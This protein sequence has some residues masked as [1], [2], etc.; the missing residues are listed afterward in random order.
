MKRFLFFI[1]FLSVFFFSFLPTKD[2][3]FGWHY[4]CGKEFFKNPKICI[5]NNFSYYLSD[6]KSANPH[7]VYDLILS[8]IFD[9]FG[10]NGLSFFY[11]IIISLC[12]FIF[13]KIIQPWWFSILAFNFT[14]F[15]SYNVLGL[16]LRSQIFSYLFFLISLYLIKK[17]KNNR[18]ILLLFPFLIFLWVN[19]HIGFFIGLILLGF[20]IFENLLL[21]QLKFKFLKYFKNGDDKTLSFLLFIFFISIIFSLIN[22]FGINVYFEI[23]NHFNSPLDKMIAEWVPPVFWQKILIG[24][25]MTFLFFLALKKQKI[26]LFPFFNTF[27]FFLLAFSAR[28]NL[29]FFYT[30][31][32]YTFGFYLTHDRVKD[33]IFEN[34]FFPLL[35]T[36]TIFFAIINIPRTLNFHN[37]FEI[38]CNQGL[39]KYPCEAIQK[40]SSLSGNVFN[41]YE[42]G[43]FLIWQKPKI[44]VFVDGRMSAWK[45]KDG[46]SPYQVF[47]EIVQTQ[48]GWNEKLKKIKTDYLLIAN[49]CFLDLLLK[50]NPKKYNWQEVYRDSNAVIYKKIN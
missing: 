47:L 8:F 19:T 30:S 3:D 45:D 42:W 46:K 32:F 26:F 6:Y 17:S 39:T 41:M 20:L 33:R 10:F 38:Y 25:L 21:N 18:K 14:F 2:T 43:G 22:P 37:D 34:L 27:F 31:V 50:N 49:G 29:P 28:R 23:L 35:V 4:R 9:H 15:L 16:G 44:K 40:Y 48:P 11:S 1:F 5:D 12:A 24:S 7:F 36:Q 13:T